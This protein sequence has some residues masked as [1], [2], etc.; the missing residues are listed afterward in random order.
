MAL[1]QNFSIS[2]GTDDVLS[3]FVESD[4]TLDTLSG[5]TVEWAVYNMSYGAPLPSPVLIH[6]I[7]TDGGVNILSSPAMTFDINIARAD[8][9]SLDAGVYYHEAVVIDAAGN[10]SM[11]MYGAMAI[12]LSML[13]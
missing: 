1:L 7:S 12:T 9:A 5:S 10:R 3:V 4:L 6:K 13:G 2:Q 11:V 8:T